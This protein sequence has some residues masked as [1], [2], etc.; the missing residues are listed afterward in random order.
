MILRPRQP[1]APRA[2]RGGFTM[3]EMLIVALI[4]ATLAALVAPRLTTANAPVPDSIASLLEADMRRTAVEA[5]ARMEPTAIVVGEDRDRWWIALASSPATELPGTVRIF[6]NGALG[7]FN[8][9]A[10]RVELDGAAAAAGTATVM[11][12]DALGGRD[13]QQVRVGLVE[14]GETEPG[15][16][17]T[18]APQRTRFAVD[19]G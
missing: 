1:A 6:G 16:F 10:L 8:G 3:I 15:G 17:W 2:P 14:P 11:Q 12:F 18:L 4:L 7:P 5:I 13:A 9:Y 19:G